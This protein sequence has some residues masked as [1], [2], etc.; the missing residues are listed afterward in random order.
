LIDKLTSGSLSEYGCNTNTRKF[1]EVA[2]LYNTEM[3]GVYSGG[4]VYE[5]SQEAS[6]YGLVTING[7]SVT[8]RADFTALQTAYANTSNP[9]GDGGYNT[10]GGASSCPPEDAPNWEVSSDSLPAIPAPAEKYMTQGAGRAQACLDLALKMPAL[11][12][13]EPPPQEAVLQLELPPDLPRPLQPPARVLLPTSGLPSTVWL[14]S[15]AV[16]W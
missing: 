6:N 13:L 5:Y 1:E 12:Q 11:A 7:N 14:L 16:W 9:T 4:L 3:T 2:A 8:E 10:T 15:S